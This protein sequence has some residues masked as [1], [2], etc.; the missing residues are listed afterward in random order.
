VDLMRQRARPY[1]FSNA[2]PPAITGASLAA[3][4]LAECPE[5]AS[6]RRATLD[7]GTPPAARGACPP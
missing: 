6:A 1:L 5:G 3:I 2:L 4:D 7:A